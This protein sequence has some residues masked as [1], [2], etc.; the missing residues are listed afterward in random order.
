MTD[1]RDAD[2]K[3]GALC[4]SL[5][6]HQLCGTEV[7]RCF[8]RRVHKLSSSRAFRQIAYIPDV[9]AS[10]LYI[11]ALTI[12]LSK[13]KAQRHQSKVLEIE[14]N[15]RSFKCASKADQNR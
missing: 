4:S 5:I 2:A 11:G 3:H 1:R 6:I 15:N 8:M 12:L 9:L 7:K 13:Q 10:D 14:N